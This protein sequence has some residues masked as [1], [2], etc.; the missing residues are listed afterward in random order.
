[1]TKT[2]VTTRSSERSSNAMSRPFLS[3]IAAAAASAAS[4]ASGVAVMLGPFR[5]EGPI[6]DAEHRPDVSR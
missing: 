4:M 2:S 5:G 6:L 3:S 1:M